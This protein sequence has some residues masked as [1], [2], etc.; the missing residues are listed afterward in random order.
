MT[1]DDQHSGA[2]AAPLLAVDGLRIVIAGSGADVVA[3][4][5]F[6]LRSGEV[7]GLVGESG[8]GKTTLALGLMGYTRRGLRI[9]EGSVKLAGQELIGLDDEHLRSLRGATV[10]YVAQDPGSA[11]NPAL[12]IGTQLREVFIG[13]EDEFRGDAAVAQRIEQVLADVG[14]EQI[15]GVLDRFPH[16]LSGGQQQR[17]MLAMAF[18]LRP[19]LIILDE[20]TTGLDVTTQRRVLDTVRD[21][22]TTYDVGAVYVSHDLAVVGDIADSLAVMYA[23]RMVE[24]GPS[25]RVFQA[26]GHPYTRG[27]LRAIPSPTRAHAL[28]GIEGQPPRPGSW[29]QGCSFRDRCEFAS[30]ECAVT[31]PPPVA[32]D[33]TL[34]WVRCL[35]AE[36]IVTLPALGELP[37]REHF[38]IEGDEP[39]LKIE[40]LRAVYGAGTEVLHG[41]DLAVGRQRCLA[42]VGESGAGKTTLARCIV[43]LHSN[44]TGTMTF[45]GKQLAPGFRGRDHD[46]LRSMQYIFQNPYTALNPRKTVGDLVEQPLRQLFKMSRSER[47][48]RVVAALRDAALN[49]QYLT[50]YPDQLS[51][52]ERQR[53]AIA[54]GLVVEPQLLVCDEVTS[55]LDVS[56]QA[57]IV[58]L[59]HELQV[60]RGLTLVLIT[61]NLALVR[62][63]ADDVVI[64]RDG[65]VV[66]RGKDVLD[67][68]QSE[69]AVQ[70][71]SDVPTLSLA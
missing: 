26:P 40:G 47:S 10:A 69:Y 36:E 13:H 61:H 64:L 5:S 11:L 39:L 17:A 68:P 37:L 43:G 55:A 35:R 15:A 48:E 2:G 6:E 41:V 27:L 28:E 14:L 58:E 34:R 22:C 32:L 70:L 9:S 20:P 56:V 3:D 57:A 29:P 21:L 7:L 18:A 19:R 51:G 62:S 16:Q 45:E 23:G 38:D 71:L 4:A 8:S 30:E 52:G 67:S 65:D 54:R 50:R 24:N 25:E 53:V 42:V 31:L 60:S 46:A 63:L 12:K 66:E 49:E 33:G 59:L 1:G 44:W